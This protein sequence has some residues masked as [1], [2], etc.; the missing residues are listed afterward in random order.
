MIA[1]EPHPYVLTP[2]AVQTLRDSITWRATTP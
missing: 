2:A 1:P